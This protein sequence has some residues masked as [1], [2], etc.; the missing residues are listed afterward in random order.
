MVYDG[1]PGAGMALVDDEFAS[2]AV[3]IAGFRAGWPARD[4]WEEDSD[5]RVEIGLYDNDDDA[6]EELDETAF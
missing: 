1:D 2:R 5:P 6:L 4:R 3:G